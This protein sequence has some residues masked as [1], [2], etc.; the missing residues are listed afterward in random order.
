MERRNLGHEE[1]A[2]LMECSLRTFNYWL[3]GVH[4]PRGSR[5]RKIAAILQ[6]E[7]YQISVA[8]ATQPDNGGEETPMMQDSIKPTIQSRAALLANRCNTHLQDF[9]DR[10]GGN[11]ERLGW[12]LVELQRRFPLDFWEEEQ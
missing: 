3:A 8:G 1:M 10:C 2:N 6:R 9:L 5:L 4:L 12:T 11:E 7:G